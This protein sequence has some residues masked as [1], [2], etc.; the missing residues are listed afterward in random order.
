MRLSKIK[1]AGF[2]SFVDPTTIHFPS[3]LVGVVGP[4]GCGKSNI[5]DAVRWVMGERSKHLRGDSMEDVIFNGS[6][7][8]KPVGQASIELMFDN[9]DGAIGGQ[10]AQY[11]EISIRRQVSRDGQS[12]YSINGTK[13]RQR[14]VKDIFLGT[15]LGP[16]SYAIIEQGMISQL[17]EAKPEDLRI[18]L[19]EAAGISKYKERRRET[20]NRMRHTRE[21]LAR[22]NDLREEVDK[23]L[24]RLQRQAKTAER[25]QR[26]KEEE[27]RVKA[28]LLCLN[29]QIQDNETREREQELKGKQT[30]SERMTVELRAAEA[31]LEKLRVEHTEANEAFN[32]VQ[33]DYY[34]LGGDISRTEQSIQFSRDAR[35]RQQHE[36]QGLQTE[37]EDTV[38]Q[39]SKDRERTLVLQ[40]DMDELEASLVHTKSAQEQSS[41]RLTE[42]E[43][44]MTTWQHQWEALGQRLVEANQIAQVERTRIEHLE[45][46]IVQFNQREARIRDEHS[47][48]SES[49]LSA[50]IERLESSVV[51]LAA[52]AENRQFQLEAVVKSIEEQR[53]TNR[54]LNHRLDQA[55]GRVQD[56]RGRLASL[57]ALQEAALGKRQKKVLEWLEEHDLANAPRLAE[58]IHVDPGWERTLETVLGPSLEA[59]CVADVDEV[60]QKIDSLEHGH[61]TLLD[62]SKSVVAEESRA[63]RPDTLLSRVRAPW[64]LASFLRG[65]YIADDLAHALNLREALQPEASVVTR[66]GIWV[67]QNWLRVVR[68]PD[69][70]AG[71]LAREMEIKTLSGKLIAD[72]AV[73]D[74]LEQDLA[75]GRATLKQLEQSREETQGE[76]N[77]AHRAQTE[78]QARLNQRS[79]QLK[80]T[81]ARRKRLSEELNEILINKDINKE[82][83]EQSTRRRNQALEV[84]DGL[85]GE[86]ETLEHERHAL[87]TALDEARGTVKNQTDAAHQI[88]L[89]LESLRAANTSAQQGV[90][91]MEQQ[92]E[93]LRHRLDELTKLIAEAAEP[94]QIQEQELEELLNQRVTVEQV[95]TESRTHVQT[96]E[97]QIRNHEQQRAS[98]E[99][100]IE[101][102]RVELDELRMAWQENHVRS[103]MLR[104][105]VDATGFV[106]EN[107][108]GELEQG[109]TASRWE[110]L[111]EELAKRINRLGPINLAAIE[112]FK[113]QSQR[114]E[115][116]D[117]QHED[118][119]EALETLEDAIRKIDRETRQ[120]FRDT[121]ERVNQRLQDTFPRLF[122]GGQAQLEMT[123]D[124]LLTTGISILARPPGKKLSTI[125]LMSGGEKA[126]TAVALVFAIFA[127]NPAPF[128]ML[129]EVDAPLDEANVGRFC[130]LVREMSET[131][132]FV[133][134]THNKATM[135]FTEQ[136]VGI[137]MHEP[138]VS[139][140]VTVDVDEA[141]QMATG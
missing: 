47:T 57:K 72:L 20:E 66:D 126:L 2:K 90:E 62:T 35:E 21:N 18:Y 36:H 34:R 114:K 40:T 92:R 22:L 104:E 75:R 93:H 98:T 134:I 32:R 30:R 43:G 1:M 61:V 53:D 60:M 50:E 136:L 125:H 49:E 3:E 88:A 121:F 108:M 140:L 128:C 45:Q 48:L 97:S 8:R 17:I 131:V 31:T 10:Y 100:D 14:D 12:K 37:L 85:Q 9:S 25:Y 16:H 42:L 105:Q 139:R 133:V 112:E 68:D 44:A 41:T 78:M 130:D 87:R 5:I 65:I 120:R 111:V 70:H 113:E 79:G 96:I 135:E 102:L 74:G 38:G 64:S 6:N 80:Q 46:Q 24:N 4:N 110:E 127:L 27:R 118:L 117:Q 76:S 59:V 54:S 109:A 69:E 116:L 83:L 71:V 51:E 13:C 115:Y 19:E 33:G 138:G 141:A 99:R 26:L 23:Q 15:G 91:R 84:I 106:L 103:Q 55:R 63:D 82:S 89:R 39:I 101:T 123:G 77:R 28:E 29:W 129:D 7:T 107:L 58:R 95:L 94:L 86:R 52:D 56:F 81:Q 137:T 122:G 73:V 119:S 67:G 132:Q 124:D 11:A